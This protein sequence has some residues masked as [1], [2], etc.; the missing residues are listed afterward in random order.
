MKARAAKE[1]GKLP[2]PEFFHSVSEGLSLVIE[3]A[4]RLQSASKILLDAK[5]A[6]GANIFT[7]LA[8]EEAAKFLILVDA[9]RCPK[10]LQE[11]RTRQLG[12]FNNHLAKGIYAE[13]ASA[14]PVDLAEL[15]RYANELRK[16]L[17]LDGPND[18]DWIFRN[19][20]WAEREEAIYVDYVETDDGHQWLAP[21][22]DEMLVSFYMSPQ[23]LQI[24]QAL[25]KTGMTTPRGLATMAKIWRRLEVN[26]KLCWDEVKARNK[27]T[28]EQL[29]RD[30]LL[31][32]N[33]S[34]VYW[35]VVQEWPMPLY[36]LDLRRAEVDRRELEGIRD[37]WYPDY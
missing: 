14:R 18:T 27:E 8:G 9:V 37:R 5:H 12:Y 35:N 20:V 10:Q 26:P 16:T 19:Q 23:A 31:D 22:D 32:P 33:C 34:D 24:S 3:N 21:R 11:I 6:Q 36:R 29:E 30:G 28:L 4:G 1:L 7:L 25:F 13:L 2:E 15:E 17:Y